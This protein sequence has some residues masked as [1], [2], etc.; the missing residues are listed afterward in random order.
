MMQYLPL[1]TA[2][3]NFGLFSAFLQC[4][5]MLLCLC[6]FLKV[7][8]LSIWAISHGAVPGAYFMDN[9]KDLPFDIWQSLN[10]TRKTHCTIN[11]Y[12]K[13]TWDIW[14]LWTASLKIPLRKLYEKIYK[15]LPWCKTNPQTLRMVSKIWNTIKSQIVIFFNKNIV[16]LNIH[17]FCYAIVYDPLN[18]DVG[19]GTQWKS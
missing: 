16:G 12:Y 2:A 15:R 6:Y 19:F 10:S 8:V 14:Y 9:R 18:F 1:L 11:G 13:W 4:A 3:H 7:W 17:N 5:C